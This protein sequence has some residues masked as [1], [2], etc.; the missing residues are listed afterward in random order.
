MRK[1]KVF[2]ID[3]EDYSEV[4]SED[5]LLG[6]MFAK[7]VKLGELGKEIAGD[8]KFS[9]ENNNKILTDVMRENIELLCVMERIT[10]L[11]K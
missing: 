3:F 8:F 4:D 10:K 2:E 9:D 6:T 11:K 1:T 7:Y 5:L